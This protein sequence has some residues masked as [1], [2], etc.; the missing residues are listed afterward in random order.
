MLTDTACK[1]ATCPANKKRLKLSD[2][3][4]LYL[5][6]SPGGAKRWFLKYRKPGQDEKAGL[7]VES[8]MAFGVYPAVSLAQAR[9]ARDAAKHTM[10]MG[11][12]PVQARKVDKL[13]TRA[14]QGDTFAEVAAEYM[15]VRSP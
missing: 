3:A 6:V 15:A 10:A 2:S 4:G 13:K 8:R 9:K 1:N 7:L 5:E 14:M 12:D 11:L